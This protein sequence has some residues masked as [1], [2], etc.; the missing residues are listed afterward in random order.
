[1]W[2]IVVRTTHWLVALLF[3]LNF[4]ILEGGETFHEWAG[5]LLVAALATRIVWGFVGPANA[6]LSALLPT[7]SRLIR[8]FS[9][10]R[11]SYLDKQGHT[12]LSGVMIIVT[13]LLLLIC[14][15]SG[16]LQTTDRFWGEEWV[17]NVHALSA[18]TLMVI[19]IFHI[20]TVVSLG[21]W[22]KRPLVRPMAFSRQKD[23]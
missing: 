7:P 18:D 22:L 23:H 1:M 2:D 6:R 20:I 4:Q 14:A 12:P 19:V 3:L 5:Y 21:Y 8:Q 13:W 15:L 16:W 10:F 17:Q 11:N 9:N